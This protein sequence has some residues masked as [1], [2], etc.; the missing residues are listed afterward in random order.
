[1]DARETI[2]GSKKKVRRE[3]MLLTVKT[4]SDGRDLSGCGIQIDGTRFS[5]EDLDEITSR[6]EAEAAGIPTAL[7][8]Q[9]HGD[10]SLFGMWLDERAI[11]SPP[12]SPRNDLQEFSR[13]LK[14]RQRLIKSTIAKLM[15][16]N[17]ASRSLGPNQSR[18]PR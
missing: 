1:M 11:C 3:M 9:Y 14:V 5:F 7:L 8:N 13:R 10:W 15:G 16:D 18:R 4:W 6:E 17:E 12:I 2:L